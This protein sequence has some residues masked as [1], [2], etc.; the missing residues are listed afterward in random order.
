M[1]ALADAS[2]SAHTVERKGSSSLIMGLLAQYG[3]D[4]E[5]SDQDTAPQPSASSSTARSN[6]ALAP[7]PP[8]PKPK[9]KKPL[10]L[11]SNNPLLAKLGVRELEHDEEES[12]GGG[13]TKKKQK[14]NDGSGFGSGLAT[15]EGQT[16]GKG[17]S[18]LIDM[19]PP[20]KRALPKPPVSTA[21]TSSTA[22]GSLGS[23]ISNG[24]G[25]SDAYKGAD[26][27]MLP[28]NVVKGK[29]KAPA[30]AEPEVDFFGIGTLTSSCQMVAL[31]WKV[32]DRQRTNV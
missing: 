27:T 20:P 31:P 1:L 3:S 14:L 5:D 17:K 19:L 21:S 16:K 13:S 28:R 32:N 18:S 26:G 4:S 23:K 8:A 30:Q 12:E 6:P 9:V 7:T 22:P 25:G 2:S 10:I 24:G 11:G 15:N 29:G